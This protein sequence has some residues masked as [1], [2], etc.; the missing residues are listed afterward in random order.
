M[1]N[2][3]AIAVDP[4]PSPNINAAF[5]TVTNLMSG[6][7]TVWIL[8]LTLLIVADVVGRNFWINLLRGL[9]KLRAGQL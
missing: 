6:L 1:S 3:S 8:A 9:P 5:H 4:P 7:G 2:P